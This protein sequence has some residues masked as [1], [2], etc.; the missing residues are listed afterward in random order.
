[1]D[2]RELERR[3]RE[4][5]EQRA[6][7]A[8]VDRAAELVAAARRDATGRPWRTRA[9]I[10]LAAAAVAGIAVGGV[11]L[12]GSDDG[13]R[14]GG[15]EATEPTPTVTTVSGW[16]TEY[17]R[18][19]QVDVPE[20]WGWGGAPMPDIVDPESGSN[21]EPI[22][23]GAE[24]YIAADGTR[25]LNGDDTMPYVGRPIIQ[26]DA[27]F[28]GVGEG[29]WRTPTAPYV[30]LG[31]PVGPGSV[32]FANGYVME[33]REVSGSTVS[34]ATQDPALRERIL[35]T[36][37]SVP[38]GELD[39]RARLSEPPRH[40]VSIEGIIEPT[41]MTVC[42]YERGASGEIELVY[43]TAVDGAAAQAVLDNLGP[44][45]VVP[46]WD[47]RPCEEPEHE[48][49]VLK[50][51]GRDIISPTQ[52][53]ADIP[54]HLGDCPAIMANGDWVLRPENVAPWAVDGLPAYVVGP[55][56]GE[57]WTYEYFRGMLG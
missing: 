18:D 57:E 54:V 17:W 30:W 25:L 33:T 10:G 46:G 42:A 41:A 44:D 32:E 51:E 16:R 15:R 27:C 36:A 38:T 9:G 52:Y 6:S 12:L 47:E 5:L 8:D 11:A 49:V 3:M 45:Q 53:V 2:E 20:D 23:C 48:W 34:V 1:M 28:G 22:D 43:A 26:T 13:I 31:A 35:D 56:S 4:G 19:V 40:S 24:A 14:S 55:R 39:C 7:H 50:M 21:G 37:G 29:R